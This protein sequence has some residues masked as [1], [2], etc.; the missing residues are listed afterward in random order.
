M[1]KA[2]RDFQVFAKPTGPLC[3]LE[4]LYCYYI[5]K[6]HLYAEGKSLRMPDDVLE[7][8]IIQH[9][10]AS[11]NQAIRFSWH[12]G[13]PTVLGLDYFRRI[14][15]LQRRHLPPGKSIINGIQTNGT[16]L[17]EEWCRFLV[18]E[19]FGVGLSL[20]GPQEMHDRYRVTKR[21]E[22]THRQAMRGYDLLRRHGIPCDIL[23][24]V[25]EQ[26]VR[27]PLELYR[28]FRQIHASYLSFL[29]LVEPQPDSESGVS[30][31]TVPAEAFG[32][33]LC[34][35]F[36][37]WL[38]HD[39]GR[40]KVQ[41]FEEAAAT[42][43]G[44][45]HE[46]CIFRPTC[47]DIPVIEHN[48][49]FFS[50]DHFVDTE[51]RLGNIRETP[52]VELLESN[53]Q[54]AFGKAK[55]DALPL[56]CRKCAVLSMC[57]GGCPKDRFITTPEGETG[58]NYLCAGYRRFLTHCLPFVIELADLWRRQS[59]ERQAPAVTARNARDSVRTGRNDP[60][61]CGSGRKYKKCCLGK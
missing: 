59:G 7:R 45:E 18:S 24:V 35:V 15:E 33:F 47:G 60:C 23:C 13:E 37:E 32:A 26:N 58:L 3:N 17:N 52:L 57:H 53:A 46:L 20:D 61:P 22:P 34:T 44:R 4:C 16:L 10:E 27:H 41:I 50:C 29:P 14:V 48:G 21:G 1:V 39:I 51:H 30:E 9:I 11:L 8:Y 25:H 2:S 31:R 40:M 28:F 55:Q 43:F 19:G 36:E 49:D 5:G 6:E 56:Y 54:R 38:N 42:A 12:G